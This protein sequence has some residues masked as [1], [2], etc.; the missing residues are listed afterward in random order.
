[1]RK[2]RV[3]HLIKSLN[4]GGAETLLAEG[5][6]FADRERFEL[7]YGY[8]NPALNALAPTLAEGGARVTCFGGDNHATMLARTGRIARHLREQRVDLLHCHLPMSGV[9]GRLA[10]RMAGVPA[11]YTEHNKPEW[12]RKPT[13]LLNAWTYDMQQ[14]VIAVSASVD[15]SIR[16]F[17]RPQVPVTIVRNGIDA[18]TFR[19]I[20]G[21]GER[22]RRRFAIPVDA[23]VVGNVAALIPQKRLHDW[24]DAAAAIHACR[25]GTRF[26]L[27][28]EGPQQAELMRRIAARGLHDVVHL[29]GAQT[30][31]RPYLAAMD[32]Y[33]MSSAFEGLPVALLEA[34]AM[35]C[36]PVCTSV[37]GIPEVL[38]DGQNGLLT[39]PGRPD[40]LAER[41]VELLDA[42]A[43]VRTA[44]LA[45]RRTVEDDFGMERMS[46]EVECVYLAVLGRRPSGY[47][48]LPS[49][50]VAGARARA[51]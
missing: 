9:V 45:A 21:D 49:R 24:V 20:A 39:D 48:H 51:S 35:H 19:R 8:F 40:R 1:M 3:L 50:Q 5:L 2:I 33:M 46:R 10:A 34:M 4:R 26:L 36:V 18:T 16:Q 41:V 43:Q 32:I 17:I 23:Q 12:Y 7:S 6:R 30:D 44:S 28:G 38:R 13:F 31:V 42:P 25:P 37:G 27:V 47:P 29:C 11:V 14:Q 15:Q 22:V